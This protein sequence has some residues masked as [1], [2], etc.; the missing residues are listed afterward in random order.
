MEVQRD[1]VRAPVKRRISRRA[2]ALLAL[3]L[4]ASAAILASQG[5]R[6]PPFDFSDAYYLA[7]GINPAN[8]LL[9]VDGTCPANDKPSCSVVDNSN[10]DPNRRNIR[11]LSTTGGFDREGNN[12]YYNIFGMVMPNTFTNDAA[13][14]TAMGIANSFEA[15][16][17]PKASG[18]PLSPALANRRQDNLFDTG[19]GYF[20]ANPLGIWTAVFVSYTPAAFNTA[21]GQKILATLAA[22]NGTDLDGTPMIRQVKEIDFL[23][24]KGLAEERTRALDGSQGPPWII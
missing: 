9:R 23:E 14:Q 22:K 17:F 19:N 7:N 15:Y 6:Q 21:E 18:D 13:G 1:R 11:V 20:V 10:T 24:G 4:G 2:S 12:L 16:I 5:S 8:I 3:V